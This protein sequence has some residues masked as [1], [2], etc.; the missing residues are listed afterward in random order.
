MTHYFNNIC[1]YQRP[2][3]SCSA[4]SGMTMTAM[5]RS[6]HAKLAR[7][8]LLVMRKNE[9]L[10]MATITRMLPPTE[11]NMIGNMNTLNRHFC[12]KLYSNSASITA[13]E[14]EVPFGDGE[15][16]AALDAMPISRV[17]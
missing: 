9:Y 4:L 7:K 14:E 3:I 13:V 17:D 16:D 2:V 11:K 5:A 15:I 10:E 1:N 6:A 8:M 12:H